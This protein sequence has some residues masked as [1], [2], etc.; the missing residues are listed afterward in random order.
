MAELATLMCGIQFTGPIINGAGAR[1]GS[2]KELHALGASDS[3]AIVVKTA[4]E[5]ARD[6]N[7]A[8]RWAISSHAS[9]NALGLPNLGYR[10]YCEMIPELRAYAKPIITS[11]NGSEV[12]IETMVRAFDRAGADLIEINLSCPNLTA[13]GQM[14]SD[15]DAVWV[16]LEKSRRATAKPLGVK[17]PPLF[18]SV[19]F[20]EMEKVL[21]GTGIDFV[22]VIN[23]VPHA[24]MMDVETE[25]T[26]TAPYGG[27]GGLGGQ[28]IKSLALANVHTWFKR[29]GDRTAIIGVG[30]VAGGR[31]A[32][33]MILAGATLVGVASALIA[34]SVDDFTHWSG[35]VA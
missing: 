11:V 29:M 30:G 31:D 32:A 3:G 33:E 17:L 16:A 1:D 27:Y 8:P 18:D 6:G 10:A 20:T 7:A 34:G 4:T 12:E 25:R 14:S 22:T 15:L 2:L 26:L 19:Q 24:L 5:Q 35:V 23:A 9:L 21:S 28:A 13:S